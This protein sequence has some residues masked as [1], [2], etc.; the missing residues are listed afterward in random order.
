MNEQSGAPDGRPVVVLLPGQGAQH[1]GMAVEL[2]GTEPGFTESMDRFFAFMGDEGRRLREDWLAGEPSVPLDDASRAQPLLFAVGYA[3]ATALR[4]RGLRPAAFLGHSVGELAAAALAGVFTLQ[5]AAA[6][7]RARS[8]AMATAPP[9]GM[10]AVAA[11]REQAESCLD[12][13]ARADGMAVAAVNAPRQVVLAGPEPRLSLVAAELRDRGV[14][15]R[16]VRS[17]QP[18]HC[19]A[20]AGAGELFEA[21]FAG[22]RLRRPHTPVWSTRTARPVQDGEALSAGFWARQLDAPVLFWPALDALLSEGEFLLVEAGP[23]KAL[24]MPVRR[25]PAVRGGRSAVVPVLP[26]GAG[27]TLRAWHDALLTLGIVPAAR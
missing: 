10:L 9:G 5:E 13:R 15:C 2:Y 14:M 6:L 17:R 4:K 8:A 20:V 21:G 26:A 23:G 7:M 16:R 11:T 27:G 22:I 3:L 19:P 12:A 25:H 1:P 18:F 24:S